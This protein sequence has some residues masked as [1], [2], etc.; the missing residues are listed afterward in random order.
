[1][2][3]SKVCLLVIFVLFY[4]IVMLRVGYAGPN[5]LVPSADGS[6]VHDKSSGLTWFADLGYFDNLSYD[7][8]K[9]AI[10]KLPGGN[11]RMATMEDIRTLDKHSDSE[12]CKVFK[13]V[14]ISVLGNKKLAVYN[15][16]VDCKDLE[17][18]SHMMA[19]L[20]HDIERKRICSPFKYEGLSITD[21]RV[22][23]VSAWV[24]C[25][26]PAVKIAK[27]EHELLKK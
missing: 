18:G 17:K 24:V 13:P 27:E 20:S 6:M 3:K 11:W 7:A 21:G 26:K 10:A 4:S 23:G 15:G 2:T 9:E 12:I 25:D 16:R 14:R 1:M 5:D 22:N 19:Y 8:Q